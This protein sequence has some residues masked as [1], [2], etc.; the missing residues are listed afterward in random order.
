MG[1][2]GSGKSMVAARLPGL[3]PPMNEERAEGV[4]A[5]ASIGNVGFDHQN[6][7]Q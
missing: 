3:L 1:A 2:L 4:A 5:V 6:W 7:G